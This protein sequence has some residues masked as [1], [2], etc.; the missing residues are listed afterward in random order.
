[1]LTIPDEIKELLHQDTCRKNIRIYF[2]GG[3]RTDICNGLIVK[4][5]V[6][7]TES[8]C[9]QDTLKF[10]LCESPVFECETVGVG[11]IK[12]ATI[13]VFC[14]VFCPPSVSGAVFRTDLQEYVYPIQYGVF[15]VESCK[16]QADLIHRKIVA[17]SYIQMNELK[18]N[19]FLNTF[20]YSSWFRNNPIVIDQKLLE[21]LYFHNSVTKSVIPLTSNVQ[22]QPNRLDL[23]RIWGDGGSNYII[24]RSNSSKYLYKIFD[25]FTEVSTNDNYDHTKFEVFE[26]EIDKDFDF[27]EYMNQC[28]KFESDLSAMLDDLVLAGL[29]LSDSKKEQI[30]MFAKPHINYCDY[31]TYA[32]M[33]Y[34]QQESPAYYWFDYIINGHNYGHFFCSSAYG[35]WQTQDAL[36]EE[37]ECAD[38]RK[39]IPI[40]KKTISGANWLLT[41]Y[42]S[43][44][45]YIAGNNIKIFAPSNGFEIEVYVNSTRYYAAFSGADLTGVFKIGVK[46]LNYSSNDAIA[47][48]ALVLNRAQAKIPNRLKSI[49]DAYRH[50][51][52]TQTVTRTEYIPVADIA[53]ID[54]NDFYAGSIEY[55]GKIAKIKRNRSVE[56]ISIKQR[57]NLMPETTLYPSNSLYPNGAVG[58]KLFPQD[59][60]SCWYDDFYTKPYGAVQCQ[61]KNSNNDDLIYVAYL[62]G[63]S[64][65]S[66]PETYQTYYLDNNFVIKNNVWT[67]GEIQTVCETIAANISGVTYMPVDFVGRGLPYVEAGDTFEI[68]TRINDSITTIVLNRTLSGEQTLTDS[69]KSV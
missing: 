15:V 56:H 4:G 19:V 32:E 46:T 13:E 21:A 9:S 54:L 47:K 60:Q 20:A 42:N 64:E 55:D 39:F 26:L 68:L 65:L 63:F 69:Y 31:G 37:L 66:D 25:A 24:R 16:R 22:W 34:A 27:Q 61:Y 28:Q 18:K 17:Y 11:N 59:Y 29:E 50:V 36:K 7:F 1:M 35:G 41:A 43:N 67:E 40:T 3:E 52:S 8:L 5:S 58:G 23:W 44:L 2:P 30:L 51:D 33:K 14:E 45:R 53:D 49:G 48:N 62:P 57:F 12:G 6:K 10:G 38:D